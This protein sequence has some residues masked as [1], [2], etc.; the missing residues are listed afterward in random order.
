MTFALR[1]KTRRTE[2]HLSQVE[3]AEAAGVS[4]QLIGK[5][6]NGKVEETRKLIQIAGALGVS[7][8]WLRSGEGDTTAGVPPYKVP[9]YTIRAIDAESMDQERDVLIDIVDVELSAGPGKLVPEFRP[10][11]RQLAYSR[12]W[13]Q[14]KRLRASD[15]VIMP[16]RGDSMR[17]TLGDGDTVL[18][19]RA[20]TS[21]VDGRIYA[22]VIGRAAK[23]KRLR[24]AVDGSLVVI[25]DNPDKGTY[26]DDIVSND[27]GASIF[28]IGRAI[29]RAGDL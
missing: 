7:P 19:N 29:Q 28:I 22:V 16:V 25:S 4:Q 27:T 9:A 5:I 26:P 2:L 10:T 1:V 14:K 17:P 15:L 11:K 8:E 12:E 6:E 23:I 20:D 18:V 13:I 24:W 3:L 21:V